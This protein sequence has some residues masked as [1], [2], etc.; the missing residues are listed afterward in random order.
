MSLFLSEQVYPLATVRL[1]FAHAL[2]SH[3]NENQLEMLYLYTQ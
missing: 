2:L 3:V 1:L